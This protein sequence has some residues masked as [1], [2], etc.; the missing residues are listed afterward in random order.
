[1]SQPPPCIVS[2]SRSCE[3]KQSDKTVFL[4]GPGSKEFSVD[5]E[6]IMETIRNFGLEPYF[7][8]L[9]DE[10]K[11]L[12]AFCDKI[13]SKIRGSG[14]CIALLN[15]PILHECLGEKKE[16]S[17]GIRAP[18]ANVYYEMGIAVTFGKKVIPIIKKGFELPF[19]IQHLDTIV[20]SDIA[21]LQKALTDSIRI[22]L[23]K[24]KPTF[25][26]HTR[27]PK[28]ELALTNGNEKPLVLVEPTITKIR[29]IEEEEND[30]VSP[31]PQMKALYES[32]AKVAT[33]AN[34][35]NIALGHKIPGN[36]LIPVYACIYNGG[37]IPAD[38]VVV[39][40]NF[41]EDCVLFDRGE[42]DGY[43]N[44]PIGNVQ[45]LSA[46][47]GDNVAIGFVKHLGNDRSTR[48]HKV[49]VRFNAE[50]EKVIDI[51]ATVIQDNHPK[52][53]FSFKI[54]VKP[55]IVEETRYKT[56]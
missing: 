7:A 4:I 5:V 55:N 11:G 29:Y 32:M 21:E 15:S 17:E 51:T 6:K 16:Q 47:T 34:S 40:I 19:D 14:F 44:P 26:Q 49:Y 8:L 53:H 2:E 38:N 1:M 37:E 31:F 41:P 24:G 18:R 35:M 42:F 28:L 36:D 50:T 25:I 56:E 43:I 33:A 20:Y 27:Q 30:N 9:S 54:T 3:V 46:E 22:Y 48:F 23:V 12:D 13:C 10:E 52:R 39:H 45:G